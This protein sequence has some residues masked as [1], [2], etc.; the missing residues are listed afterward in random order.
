MSALTESLTFA[1]TTHLKWTGR[2][3]PGLLLASLVVTLGAIAALWPNALASGDPEA[4]NLTAV[5]QP[6][7]AEHW[8]GTDQLGRDVYT[9]V[10]HGAGYSLSIG[11]GA[12]LVA[13]FL[14]TLL[15]LLAVY[16]PW[17]LDWLVGRLIDI[18]LAFPELLLALIVVA[19]LGRGPLNTVLA[20]GLGGIAGY[21]RLVRSQLLKVRLSGYVEHARVLGESSIT[22]TLRHL[23]PNSLR[24]LV[25]V[26]TIGVGS[27]I[28][29][30]STLSYL[31]LGVVP[32]TP[33]WGAMLADSRSF[34]TVAPWASLLPAS[35]VAISV[36]SITVL[37]RWVQRRLARGVDA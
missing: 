31:G 5:L 9:R 15:G 22:I 13:L 28:L 7:S 27:A 2:V 21:A 1:P 12:M 16:A 35:I 25:V 20:V 11:L 33:E 18:L 30:A 10:V 24:P 29:N 26:A 36:I 37:G 32:P 23:L 4:A 19:V 3:R 14:G 6:P 8:F 17:R 34:L